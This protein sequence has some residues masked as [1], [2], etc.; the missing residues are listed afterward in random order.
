VG[1]LVGLSVVTVGVLVG[2]S[3]VTVGVLVGALG[4]A[5]GLRTVENSK[6]SSAMSPDQPVPIVAHTVTVT[7]VLGSAMT[8]GWNASFCEPVRDHT[9]LLLY[10]TS[11]VP[12]S[13]PNMW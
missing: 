2:L 5:V 8:A 9:T 13:F 7:G 4:A 1:V 6:L 11:S 12:T 10:C 3:V